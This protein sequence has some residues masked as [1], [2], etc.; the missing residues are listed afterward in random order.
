MGKFICLVTKVSCN[1]TK[2]HNRQKLELILYK[3][4]YN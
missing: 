3:S 1:C 4:N 2:K